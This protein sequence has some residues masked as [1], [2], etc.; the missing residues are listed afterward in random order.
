MKTT[1]RWLSLLLSLIMVVGVFAVAPVSVSAATYD[2]LFPVNNGGKIAYAY[3]YSSGYFNGTVF[4]NGIDIHS[5]G[6]DNIYAVDNGTVMA[7]ANACYHVNYGAA[8]EHNNTFGNY[9][10]IK[11][12]NGTFCR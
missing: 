12:S 10:K 4:H 5:N 7:T 3:G 6:D 9:I 11:H 2:L 8:C 1:K